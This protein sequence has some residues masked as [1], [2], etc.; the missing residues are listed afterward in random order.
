MN[1][2]CINASDTLTFEI[3]GQLEFPTLGLSIRNDNFEVDYETNNGGIGKVGIKYKNVD[4]KLG[5]GSSSMDTAYDIST[6]Y[7]DFQGFFYFN[8]FGTDVYFQKF[9]GYYSERPDENRILYYPEMRLL[10]MTVNEYFKIGGDN[11]ISS[12]TNPISTVKNISH[13]FFTLGSLSYRGINSSIPLIP[14]QDTANLPYF[15]D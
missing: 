5:F 7:F 6:K 10:T 3:T 14:N 12:F 8:R 4:F 1:S 9:E 13:L 11:N 2:I 15:S